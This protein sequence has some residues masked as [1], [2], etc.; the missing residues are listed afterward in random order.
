M[1]LSPP[2]ILRVSDFRV[3]KLASLPAPIRSITKCWNRAVTRFGTGGWIL[4]L[5]LIAV[6]CACGIHFAQGANPWDREVPGKLEAGMPLTISDTIVSGLWIAS[7][8]NLVLSLVLIGAARWWARP[9]SPSGKTSA[10]SV[11]HSPHRRN[12]YCF[13]GLVLLAVIVA[14][15]LRAPRLDHSWFNDEEQAFRKFTW[16]SYQSGET[17]PDEL[18]FKEAH[19]NRALFYSV[20]GN[21]HVFHT[22]VA[23]FAHLTWRKFAS[24]GYETFREPVIRLEPFLSGLLTLVVLAGWLRAIGFPVAGVTAA[25]LLALHPWVLRYSVEARGYSALLLFVCLALGCLTFALRTHRWRWWL[26]YGL[27]QCLYL[28]CFAGAIYLAVAMNA[29]VLT[30]LLIRREQGDL[31]RWFVACTLGAMA[32]LQVMTATVLRIW[33]WIQAPEIQAIPMTFSY[34]RDFWAHLAIGAP[35]SGYAPERHQGVGITSLADNSP[36]W[37]LAFFIVLPLV[38]L[39]GL[40]YGCLRSRAL[41]F[42]FASLALAAGLIWLHQELSGLAFYGWYALYLVIGFI[43]ALALS[44]EAISQILTRSRHR[45]VEPSPRYATMI[46]FALGAMI[47]LG[48][49][50]MAREPIDRIRTFDHHPMRQ[51]VI[52]VR[53]EAPAISST[54]AS[55][56]TGSLGSGANQL[57]SY[58]PRVRWIR[59]VEDLDALVAEAETSSKPLTLYVCGPEQLRRGHPE[60]S[61]RL[62]AGDGRF[63]PGQYLPGLEEFWSFRIYHL[64][65]P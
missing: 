17:N 10:T 65:S 16:G 45:G 39:A 58:D 20:N 54:H 14:A 7:G 34:F 25:W 32:F 22:A 57:H 61:A 48:Y 47:V 44:G 63:E 33:N 29:L 40:L 50:W 19:W 13:W 64:K 23:K 1:L 12:S 4:I 8:I 27:C 55:L 60:L 42:F 26:G 46:P 21:N 31:R 24:P 56:L 41:R 49:A 30:L 43:V 6:A 51:A 2:P 53:G 28:L 5:V 36:T 11:S 18:E 37:S 38:L 35:W 52:V 3:M 62:E 15:S 59:S 9:L